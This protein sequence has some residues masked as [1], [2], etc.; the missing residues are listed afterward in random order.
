[1]SKTISFF[2]PGLPVGKGRHR[3]APLMKNGK[4]VI[5][6]GGRPII[7]H[8][9]DPKTVQYENLVALIGRE[10]MG[11]R[12]PFAGAIEITLRILLKIP[13]SMPKY[14]REKVAAGSLVPISKPDVDNVEKAICDAL[15]HIVWIDDSQI[16]DVAKRKR[17]SEKPGVV[18]TI[19][20]L[21]IDVW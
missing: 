13:K 21:D 16:V 4:P 10:E 14:K 1:M 9:S 5:G 20:E 19:Q 3:S 15:N 18:V 2:V 12:N 6:K 8:H 7:I 17:F 11:G